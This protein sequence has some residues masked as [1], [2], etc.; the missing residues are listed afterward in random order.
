M[1]QRLTRLF[2]RTTPAP[3][4]Q[5]RI[6]GGGSDDNPYKRIGWDDKT[7]RRQ[8][9]KRWMTKYRRGGPYA[10]A[11]DAYWL[12]ALS[13][14]WKLACEEGNEAPKDRVQAWL[15]Q[16]HVD[17]DDILKQ[18]I[19]SAKLAGDAYQEII[20]NR[21][22]DGVWGVVTRDPSSFRK[23]FDTYGRITGYRQFVD[24]ENPADQGILIAP[25][26][27][28]N[29][30]LDQ[31]PGDVYGL[32]IWDRAEDDIE[33]DCDIIESTTKAIHRHGTPKQQWSVGNDDRPATEADLQAVEKEIKSVGAKTD[34]ATDHTVAINMLDT[35]GVANVDTYSNVSL[36]RVAC[37]L[38]VPEEMLGL[39]RGSTEATANVR[40]GTFLDKIST[41]QQIVART[42][43][44][45]LIDRITGV[46]G[47]VWLEFNDVNPDDESKIADWIAK[48]RQSNPLDPDAIV[49]AAWARE[50]LGIP[51]DEDEIDDKRETPD[52]QEE[53]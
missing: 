3:E 34:F 4:P 17:L 6:V 44:R 24:E 40:M 45:A 29:L 21:A 28:L 31:A 27:I 47:V 15:D 20:P 9:I 39:G 2:S 51:P 37:A 26:R 14:G 30:V 41:I 50:R 7:N 1:I 35:T 10:D 18:A 49:P 19:L 43:S 46:P 13:N 33:R 12:F 32:S 52:E 11:I 16:P 5:T 25:D 42:Y 8:K 38:G 53:P 23:E 48:I 36:Q 22:G